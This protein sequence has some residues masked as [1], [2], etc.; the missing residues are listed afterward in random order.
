MRLTKWLGILVVLGLLLTVLTTPA[1]TATKIQVTSW[2]SFENGSSLDVL[3][4]AFEA[5]HP[6]IKV[7]YVQIPSSEYYTKVLTMIAGGTAPDVAM[8]GMDKLGAWVPRGALQDLT[9]YIKKSGMDLNAF[10]P[11]VQEAIK[12]EGKIYAIPRDATTSVVAYNK[13]LFDQAGV[14]YPQPGWTRQDFLETA[15]KLVQKDGNQTKVYGYAFDTFV[16]GFIDWLYLNKASVINPEGTGSGFHLSNAVEVLKFLQ[17]M[18]KEGIAPAPALT[19]TFSNA[20]GA[21][22][23]ERAAMFVTTVGWANSFVNA[24]S[25]DWD[26]VPLPLWD[27]DSA[28]CTRLWVNY[29]VLPKGAKN[30]EAAWK[31]LAF[32]GSEEGQRIVGETKMGIPAIPKIAF[33][34]AFAQTEGKPEHKAYFLDV[35]DGARPFPLFPQSDQFYAVMTREFDAMW[36]GERSVEEAVAALDR[37]TKGLFR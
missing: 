22:M 18:V 13:K 19:K 27:K 4:K 9:P 35:M 30:S 37:A 15:R 1:M 17:G 5:K 11:A 33:G 25:L 20:S 21:F 10:F 31:L 23:S 2:W 14:K 7:E 24:P 26:V 29:W 36:T 3:K 16:D 8:L 12:Y 6:E 28:P 34:P 32:L